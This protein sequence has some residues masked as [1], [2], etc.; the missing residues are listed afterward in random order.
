MTDKEKIF[1]LEKMLG[2]SI[3][4][5]VENEVCSGCKIFHNRDFR[6]KSG[7]FC[8]DLIY[9]GLLEKVKGVSKK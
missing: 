1:L 4:I 9:D 3:G 6:C 5:Q 7:N 8:A 2:E